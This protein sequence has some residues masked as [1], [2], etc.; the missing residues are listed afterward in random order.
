M[1]EIVQSVA[2]TQRAITCVPHVIATGFFGAAQ[3]WIYATAIPLN[4]G[5]RLAL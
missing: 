4:G 1:R 3:R 5:L 2:G